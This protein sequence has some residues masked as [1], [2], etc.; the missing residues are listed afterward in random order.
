MLFCIKEEH[1]KEKKAKLTQK[2]NEKLLKDKEE[3]RTIN[4]FKD[5]LTDTTFPE[6]SNIRTT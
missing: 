1:N 4:M 2:E 6:K 3:F 5:I